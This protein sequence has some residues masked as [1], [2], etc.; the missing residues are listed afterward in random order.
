MS[1]EPTPPPGDGWTLETLHLDA[2]SFDDRVQ[3][4]AALSPAAIERYAE[5]YRHGQDMHPLVCFLEGD[6]YWAA[7]GF[8]RRAAARRA[9]LGRLPFWVRPGTYL[10]ARAFARADNLRHLGEPLT[11]EDRQ[12]MARGAVED[13]PRRGDSELA[14]L[15]GVHH[16]TV[17]SE[18]RRLARDLLGADPNLSD[19]ALAAATGCRADDLAEVRASLASGAPLPAYSKQLK[20]RSARRAA[21]E[22]DDEPADELSRAA[23]AARQRAERAARRDEREAQVRPPLT[24]QQ[25]RAV[26]EHLRDLFANSALPDLAD[27]AE[28][29]LGPADLADLDR[30][31]QS[32]AKV[33]PHFPSERFASHLLGVAERLEESKRL[34]RQAAELARQSV[35]HS[36]CA[37]CEGSGRRGEADCAD[38]Y[39]LGYLS[40]FR[41]VELR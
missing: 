33:F 9:G 41:V 37:A 1:H 2:V 28:R 36:V 15:A 10:E 12:R 29:L 16:T 21:V 35:P 8:T 38:C 6:V 23:D 20:Q 18:R 14:E 17:R 31:A 22:G 5:R 34:L 26:P 32:L 24:D 40:F 13:A 25:G 30:R 11:R 27:D 7:A 39:G 4:R 19:E 3:P